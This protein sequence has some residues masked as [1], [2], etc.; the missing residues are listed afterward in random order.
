MNR[1]IDRYREKF[2]VTQ[3]EKITLFGGG[4]VSDILLSKRIVTP[5]SPVINCDICLSAM[6]VK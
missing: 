2:M 1:W 5:L 3:T 4:V 6:K